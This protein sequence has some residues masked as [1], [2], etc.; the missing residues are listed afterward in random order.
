MSIWARISEFIDWHLFPDNDNKI[1]QFEGLA[2]TMWYRPMMVRI[3]GNLKQGVGRKLPY[4]LPM[5][6][7]SWNFPWTYVQ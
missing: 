7:S 3:L 2:I 5:Q 4:I 1:V 6:G